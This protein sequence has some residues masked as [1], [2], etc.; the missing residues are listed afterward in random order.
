MTALQAL[1]VTGTGGLAHAHVVVE[2][3]ETSAEPTTVVDWSAGGP[4]VTRRG[5]GD[6]DRF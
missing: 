3:G 5:A 2:A 6:P 1:L 4:E